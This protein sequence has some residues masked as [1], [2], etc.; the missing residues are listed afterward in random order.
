MAKEEGRGER[1]KGWEER[2]GAG[3][4]SSKVLRG[5]RRPWLLIFC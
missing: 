4:S 1:G 2:E 5:D 3:G